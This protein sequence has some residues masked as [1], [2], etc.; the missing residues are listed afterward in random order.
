MQMNKKVLVSVLLIIAMIAGIAAG[1]GQTQA[2]PA[3]Q[4]QTTTA[5]QPAQTTAKAGEEKASET[6]AAAAA[7]TTAAATTAAAAATTVKVED[8]A[9]VKEEDLV[10]VEVSDRDAYIAQYYSK[11]EPVIPLTQ[12][13]RA[14]GPE[15]VWE[16]GDSIDNNNSTRWAER[17][18]GIKWKSTWNAVN[19]E[20]D[21]QK[22][23]L[24]M[25]ANDL[26]DFIRPYTSAEVIKM[27]EAGQIIPLNEAI[28]KYLSPLAKY[29]MNDMNESTQGMHF[30][31]NYYNGKLYGLGSY[32]DMVTPQANHWRQ[33]ILTELGFSEPPDSIE[34]IDEVFAAYKN[35]YP[36]GIAWALDKELITGVNAVFLAYG[37]QSQSWRKTSDG[38]LA[39]GSVLPQAKDALA[40]LAEWYGKGYL[41]PEFIVKDQT[42]IDQDWGAG[43]MLARQREWWICWG[44][45]ITLQANVPSALISAG[46]YWRGPA[47]EWGSLQIKPNEFEQHCINANVSEAAV[48]AIM[49][50]FNFYCDSAFRAHKDLQEKF[51]H[52]YEYEPEKSAYNIEEISAIRASGAKQVPREKFDIP[53]DKEGPS[54]GQSSWF[55]VT[56]AQGEQFGY[57]F[58]QRPGQLRKDFLDIE[59]ALLSN[60]KAF[61]DNAVIYT[62]LKDQWSQNNLDSLFQNIHWAMKS[63]EEEHTYFNMQ[64]CAATPSQLKYHANLLAL[65]LSTFADII[66]GNQSIDAFDAFVDEWMQNGGADITD[67]INVWWDS[68]K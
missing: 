35:L 60:N 5:S 64:W 29:M 25:A 63:E 68:V 23:S 24:A 43:N 38:K 9:V 27:A 56:V 50:Q 66:M 65:E 45:H 31:M 2:P 67:E 46:D 12:N 61:L 51:I 14:G 16:E 33:D 4:N 10:D 17:T 19:Q 52:Y 3:E 34:E 1:C 18:V 62:Q 28:D 13:M 40:K 54:N 44:G 37:T 15:V 20:E 30:K 8:E 32:A 57:R 41:D 55:A 58:N 22:L 49:T 48:K 11:A 42:M 47:G 59:E 26:P 6:T 36:N 53:L 21:T 39:Y 7:E